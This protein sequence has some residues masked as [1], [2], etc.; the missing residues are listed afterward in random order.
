LP[1]AN[2]QVPIFG[3]L[4]EDFKS[5]IG[6]WQSAISLLRFLMIGMLAATATEFTEL[7]PIRRGFLVFSRNVVT[8]LTFAALQYNII[9][10]HKSFSPHSFPIANSQLPIGNRHLAIPYSLTSVIVPAPTVRPPSRIA[11]R[12]PFS[13]AMGVINSISIAT[14]SPGI[15]I[16]TP[17]GNCAT[18]VTSVV[19][20]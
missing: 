6:N 13:I 16:S 19:R 17:A 12:S 14:L 15:T 2:C 8:A 9:A 7:K 1:I 10:W 3:V 20:K 11:N 4:C 18:P 5:A